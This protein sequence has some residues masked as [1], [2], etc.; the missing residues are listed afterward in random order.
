M[1]G[2][3]SVPSNVRYWPIAAIASCIIGDLVV[4]VEHQ[5][6]PI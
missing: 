3:I 6:K 5:L 1:N 4:G 2:G